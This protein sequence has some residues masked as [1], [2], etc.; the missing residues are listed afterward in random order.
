MAETRQ[1]TLT[2]EQL[3]EVLGLLRGADSAELKLTVPEGQTGTTVRALGIDPLDARVRQVFFFDTPALSLN[4]AGVVARAR[5]IQ[6]S[7]ADT[8]VKLRPVVP[9][10][11]PNRLRKD[12]SFGVEVDAMPGGFVCSA[13]LKGT[14]TNAEVWD[15]FEGRRQI[16]KLFSKE[17]RG[18]FAAHAPK[19]VT[20]EEV[21][22]LGPVNVLKLKYK[23]EAFE[24]KLAVELW[25]YPN[26]SRILELSTKCAP[27]EAFQVATEARAF[28]TGRGVDLSGEQQ[29]KTKSALQYFSKLLAK[30]AR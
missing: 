20:L 30:A 10:D 4:A 3:R 5:R 11:I 7:A 12:P 23:P 25:F 18:Y 9:D 2:G 14:S 13:S 24:R 27:S 6:D 8:V 28:L 1:Q 17:Q 22:V 15:V 29:T 19:G 26:G 21:S 16:K